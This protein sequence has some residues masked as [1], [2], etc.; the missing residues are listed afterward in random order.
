MFKLKLKIN[1]LLIKFV[2]H[3]ETHVKYLYMSET[4]SSNVNIFSKNF[5]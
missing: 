1:D 4:T 2:I 3:A 5:L